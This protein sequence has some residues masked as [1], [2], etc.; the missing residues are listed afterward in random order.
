[1]ALQLKVLSPEN[2]LFEGSVDYIKLPG[3]QGAFE[4]LTDHAAIVSTL[5]AGLVTYGLFKQEPQTLKIDSGLVE[6][7]NN[8]VALCVTTKS[9][10]YEYS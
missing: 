5:T 2:V 7:R 9:E 10:D 3:R 4:V 6:V 1:M 8:A